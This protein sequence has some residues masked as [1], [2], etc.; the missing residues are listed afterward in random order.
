MRLDSLRVRSLFLV[1][2]EERKGPKVHDLAGQSRGR[3]D[4]AVRR[5]GRDALYQVPIGALWP[6]RA[7]NGRIRFGDVL[8]LQCLC[9]TQRFR[10]LNQDEM[11]Q[12]KSRLI[13]PMRGAED[14]QLLKSG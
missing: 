7:S 1:E 13:S 2:E 3:S 6:P 14:F 8:Q 4:L 12:S 11:R 9:S 10:L 5:D